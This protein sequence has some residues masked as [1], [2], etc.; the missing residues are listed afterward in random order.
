M[1]MDKAEMREMKRFQKEKPEVTEAML[2]ELA[3]KFAPAEIA[4]NKRRGIME[5]ERCA[6][7][8]DLGGDLLGRMTIMQIKR[9][10]S[11]V[12]R[13]VKLATTSNAGPTS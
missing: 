11:Q 8:Y 1:I 12:K 3:A 9:F 7:L 5:A 6:E 4:A 10:A 13:A 2:K